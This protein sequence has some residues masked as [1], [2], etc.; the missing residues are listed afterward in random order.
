VLKKFV[1]KFD[2]LQIEAK[3]V[4]KVC[5]PIFVGLENSVVCKIFIIKACGVG[6]LASTIVSILEK[7]DDLVVFITNSTMVCAKEL[8]VAWDL[9]CEKHGPSKVKHKKEI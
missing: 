3:C 4:P 7:D 9:K 1:A 2:R 6:L 8:C 5:K